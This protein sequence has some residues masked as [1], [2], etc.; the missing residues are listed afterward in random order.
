MTGCLGC[1]TRRTNRTIYNHTHPPSLSS[2]G[3]SSIL[4]ISSPSNHQQDKTS[5]RKT[6]TTKR[7]L[8]SYK[9]TTYKQPTL[10]TSIKTTQRTRSK[11]KK[12]WAPSYLVYVSLP[13]PTS[14]PPLSPPFSP[15]PFSLQ[16]IIVQPPLANA[17]ADT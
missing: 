6:S 7:H 5:S 9:P 14:S 1:K 4:S 10:K 8:S 12:K 3:D 16:T 15:L 11:R 2:N 17:R 13:F